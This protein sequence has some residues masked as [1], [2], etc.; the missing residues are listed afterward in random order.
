M[1]ELI[2]KDT[3]S[4]DPILIID[5]Y[6]FKENVLIL[7]VDGNDIGFQNKEKHLHAKMKYIREWC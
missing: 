6:K 3:V 7:E 2:T 1:N 4:N 5:D